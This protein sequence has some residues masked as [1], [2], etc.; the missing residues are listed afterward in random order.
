MN[1]GYSR[2]PYT[3]PTRSTH[4][5]DEER[6]PNA[7]RLKSAGDGAGWRGGAVRTGPNSQVSE[8]NADESHVRSY[9]RVDG[10]STSSV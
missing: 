10:C 8:V 2:G 5:A 3:Q 6:M 1:N 9:I 4:N 7:K